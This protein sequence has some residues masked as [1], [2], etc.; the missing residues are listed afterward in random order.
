MYE[1][2]KKHRYSMRVLD[3]EHETL[4]PLIF[5]TTAEGMTLIR[6]KFDRTQ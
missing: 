2:E 4:T 1:N 3:T 5:T 6:I